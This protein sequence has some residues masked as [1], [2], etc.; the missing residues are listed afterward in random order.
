MKKIITLTAIT[1]LSLTIFAQNTKPAGTSKQLAG[2]AKDST[3]KS[4]SKTAPQRYF[5]MGTKEEFDLLYKVIAD[6]RNVTP[7]QAEAMLKWIAN[8]AAIVNDTTQKK[9]N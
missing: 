4:V 8:K 5:M 6:P 7:N 9:N 2:P 3:V 1:L